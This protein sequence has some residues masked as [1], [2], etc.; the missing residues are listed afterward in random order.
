MEDEGAD[1]DVKD[2]DGMT[3]L[4][5]ANVA[6][7]YVMLS[8]SAKTKYGEYPLST[9]ARKGD[10]E[11]VKALIATGYKHLNEHDTYPTS[12]NTAL[13]TYAARGCE[14][15]LKALIVAGANM[16]EE[17]VSGVMMLATNDNSLLLN[18]R[19]NTSILPLR[20]LPEKVMK[21]V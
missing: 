16:E 17:S 18:L 13:N 14:S 11:T 21:L 10:D 12:Y 8:N 1:K 5:H 3:H 7:K 9:A 2:I 15:M 4:D 20:Q 19:V 6:R